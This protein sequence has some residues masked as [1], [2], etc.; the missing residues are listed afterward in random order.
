MRQV[1]DR[2]F[3]DL[4]KGRRDSHW[5]GV[6]VKLWCQCGGVSPQA[7]EGRVMKSVR[8]IGATPLWSV[9]C[10]VPSGR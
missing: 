9:A 3:V 8:L 10:I 2:K 7:N 6:P 4:P 5:V 1:I